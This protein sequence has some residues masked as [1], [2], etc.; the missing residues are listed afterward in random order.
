MILS[1]PGLLLA[2]LFLRQNSPPIF[3]TISKPLGQRSRLF[4]ALS[5]LQ[6]ASRIVENLACS[7][8]VERRVMGGQF[9]QE[10]FCFVSEIFAENLQI[11]HLE[12]GSG[13]ENSDNFRCRAL[14]Q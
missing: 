12:S 1:N 7:L 10:P 11:Q 6:P 2:T 5:L 8:D 9:A 14:G 13:C 3:V 4:C